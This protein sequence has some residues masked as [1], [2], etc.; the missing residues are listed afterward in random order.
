MSQ[1]CYLMP[2][3]RF[4]VPQLMIRFMLCVCVG[5]NSLCITRRVNL[6]C[7]AMTCYRC[8]LS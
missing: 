4:R 6:N 8:K 1:M 2:V 7:V 3:C 5:H